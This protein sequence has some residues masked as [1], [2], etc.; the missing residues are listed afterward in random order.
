MK[1][2]RIA[3]TIPNIV[4]LSVLAAMTLYPLAFMAITS[5]KSLDQYNSQFWLPTWPFHLENYTSAWV[6]IAPYMLNSIIVTA[7]STVGVVA[8]S[9]FTAY[10]FARFDFPGREF[11]YYLV[12]FLLMVP[13]VLTLVP[14]FL[15]VK[16]LGLMDTRWALILP[17]IAGGQVLAIFIMRSFFAGLPEELFEAARIDGAGELRVLWHIGIPLT[18]PILIT[19]A[20]LQILSSWNDY[21]WPFLV[22]QS[23]SLKTL[24]VGLVTFQ[25]R[26]FTDWGP[27]MAGYT[28]ASLPLLILFFLGMRAFMEGLTQGGLKM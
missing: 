26:F 10:A 22:I 12:I 7:A 9:V 18:K 28:L 3:I 25:G 13:A 6:A 1:V 17:Y 24:V 11:F 2:K 21:L 16:S 5:F 20:L 4:V 19:I 14:S 8:L 23:N 15:L 27:L